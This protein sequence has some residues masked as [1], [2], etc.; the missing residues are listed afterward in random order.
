MLLTLD[1]EHFANYGECKIYF[2]NDKDKSQTLNEIANKIKPYHE[3]QNLLSKIEYLQNQYNI[4]ENNKESLKN[5]LKKLHLDKKKYKNKILNLD[6]KLHL[7]NTEI[8][9]KNSLISQYNSKKSKNNNIP[10]VNS[11]YY[12]ILLHNTPIFHGFIDNLDNIPLP[13]HSD[14]KIILIGIFKPTSSG[15]WNFSFNNNDTFEIYIDDT[16]IHNSY[17][18]FKSDSAYKIQ[19]IINHSYSNQNP[20]ISFQNPRFNS[21]N[22]SS[23]ISIPIHKFLLKGIFYNN[24]Q[25]K[26]IYN[27][28]TKMRGLTSTLDNLSFINKNI[29]K[30][31]LEIKGFFIP[32]ITGNWTIKFN[33]DILSYLWI[34]ESDNKFDN[35][36]II[37]IKSKESF[38]NN[39]IFI[40]NSLETSSSKNIY[41]NKNKIYSIFINFNVS[42]NY[43]NSSLSFI[44][45]SSSNTQKSQFFTIRS[46]KKFNSLQQKIFNNIQNYIKNSDNFIDPDTL[47]QETNLIQ[48]NIDS[49]SKL[50]QKYNTILLSINN[51]ISNFQNELTNIN[52]NTLSNDIHTNKNILNS[53]PSHF[54][55]NNQ[56]IHLQSLY[57]TVKNNSFLPIKGWYELEDTSSK[58]AYEED[59]KRI[60]K[61]KCEKKIKDEVNKE[62]KL[63]ELQ[64]NYN[65]NDIY[66][67]NSK[68]TDNNCINA[69][70][71][72]MTFTKNM[73]DPTYYIYS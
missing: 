33:S 38:N 60:H 40:D 24:L 45:P 25:W 55:D 48:N 66:C 27:N 26:V 21:S 43:H 9:S 46:I 29:I 53:Y 59:D 34:I 37:S 61:W 19:F 23:I 11:F 12:Y 67:Y 6:S 65:N 4:S 28:K 52:N 51:D 58:Y 70:K 62:V 8:K 47:Y 68:T 39:N 13:F 5:K 42:K 31:D 16:L 72:Q 18:N 20:S 30:D 57:D 1:I 15:I 56:S 22:I 32:S 71:Y 69:D 44:P 50:L 73:S 64:K 10:I 35:N 14:C 54:H 7:Y 17:F 36:S 63:K 41:L 2:K 3:Y 49:N